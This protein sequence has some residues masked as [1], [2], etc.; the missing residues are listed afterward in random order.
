MPLTANHSSPA[1][2]RAARN[3]IYALT[4]IVPRHRYHC[5]MGNHDNDRSQRPLDANHHRPTWMISLSRDHKPLLG[6]GGQGGVQDVPVL[7]GGG[8][9]RPCVHRGAL[10]GPV[11]QPA[12]K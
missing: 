3:P 1:S 12:V 5:G 11:T 9:I 4:G 10:R 7:A 8:A 2:L 6:M